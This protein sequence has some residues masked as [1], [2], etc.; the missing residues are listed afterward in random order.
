M[1]KINHPV[2]IED[3]QRTSELDKSAEWFGILFLN[4]L[5]L[6]LMLRLCILRKKGQ[7]YQWN[8][9]INCKKGDF[10]NENALT[11][12][13]TLTKVI[14]TFN[15]EPEFEKDRIVDKDRIVGLRNALA[16]G[17]LLSSEPPPPMRLY[18]FGRQKNGKVRVIIAENM[19]RNWF[20]EN[21][22]F[23]GSETIRIQA[24]YE[25]LKEQK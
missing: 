25:R 4:L 1:S 11:N 7:E 16:H 2:K 15:S 6:E 13:D 24:V 21:V 12:F 18:K 9:Q 23:I 17:R 5:S 8:E 22:K 20:Q 14:E 3:K 19:T 10:I